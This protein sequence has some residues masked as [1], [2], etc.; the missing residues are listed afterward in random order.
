MI[1]LA[2][3]F[4]TVLLS[5]FV[6]KPGTAVQSQTIYDFKVASLMATALTLLTL[7]ERRY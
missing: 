6:S 1:K 5:S 3:V 7:K 4:V 2:T